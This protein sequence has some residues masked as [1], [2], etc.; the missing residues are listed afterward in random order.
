MAGN[1]MR[2]LVVLLGTALAQEVEVHLVEE[3]LRLAGW[4]PPRPRAPPACS[5]HDGSLRGS[6]AALRQ[7]RARAPLLVH[8]HAR[9]LFARHRGQKH[10]H[11][12]R[13][14]TASPMW[15][16]RRHL[17]PPAHRPPSTRRQSGAAAGPGAGGQHPSRWRTTAPNGPGVS[18]ISMR[19]RY[20]HQP[21]HPA[22]CGVELLGHAYKRRFSE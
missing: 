13:K 9:S 21:Q 2:L 18:L 14:D 22:L 6:P 10:L 3:E 17:F 19:R 5:C 7:S 8:R 15:N 11:P 1:E 20:R 16:H 12:L 4:R